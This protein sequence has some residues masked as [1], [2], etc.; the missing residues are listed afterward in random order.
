[1]IEAWLDLPTAGLFAV[2]AAFYGATAASLTWL[3]FSAAT[4]PA[5]RHFD[6]V[7]PP[8]FA[9]VSILFALLTGF[10]ASDVADRNRQA[11]RAVQAEA[12]ELHNVYTLSL[13]SA[14]DMHDIRAALASYVKSVVAEE[15]P[16]MADDR[17]SPSTAAG[18]DALLREVS[19]PRI[20]QA[21]GNPVQVVLL[22]ATVRAGT[23]RSIRLALAADR[24]TDIKWATILL[25][26]M[27][28]QISIALVHLHKRNAHVAALTVFSVSAVIALGL[29]ALQERPFAGDLQVPPGPLLDLVKLTTQ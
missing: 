25:L 26:G 22:N 23:A 12:G 24:T 18:Y 8:F 7:V 15:W 19:D 27:M 6:G 10:L 3:A 2:L 13:A 20:A 5:L 11:F 17:R 21:A 1:M 29:I 14:S 9:A 28:T 4:G 16:A